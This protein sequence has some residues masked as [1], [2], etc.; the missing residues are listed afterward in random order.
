[1]AM[2]VPTQ[3]QELHT[4]VDQILAQRKTQTT[5]PVSGAKGKRITTRVDARNAIGASRHR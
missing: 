2:R 5:A 1:M 4:V 3:P